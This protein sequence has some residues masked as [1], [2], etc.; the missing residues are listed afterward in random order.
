MKK[1]LCAGILA[2]L[3]A[4]PG[5]LYATSETVPETEV[6]YEDYPTENL[7]EPDFFQQDLATP[8][9]GPTNPFARSF[10]VTVGG[11]CVLGVDATWPMDE[12]GTFNH[13]VELQGAGYPFAGL[14]GVFGQDDLSLVNLECPLTYSQDKQKRA[15]NFRGYPDA[16]RVLQAGSVE[17]VNIANN[18]ILDFGEE[19]RLETISALDGAGIVYSGGDAPGIFERNGVRVGLLGYS[20]PYP[21]AGKDITGDVQALRDAGCHIVIASFHWGSEFKV[22]FTGEQRKLGRAAIDAGADVVVGHHPHVIQGIE[23]Y[24]D[25]YILYS[26]GNLVYGGTRKLRDSESYIAQLTFS[27]D[28]EVCAQGQ[29]P[30]LQIYPVT[31][32]EGELNAYQPKLTDE[33]RYEQIMKL[34]YKRSP[35]GTF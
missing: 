9:P 1:T 3:C 15:F 34:I 5:P 23:R 7:N 6:L 25:R 4:L 14:S 27:V 32:T 33:Q 18:H 2:L 24:K 29:P 21:K 35:K 16:V 17:A 13:I 28:T 11:D 20:Y 12:P 30:A 22:D 8:T 10:S 19:G 31:L 26:L